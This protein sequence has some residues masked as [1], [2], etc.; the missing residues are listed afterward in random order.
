MAAQARSDDD[1]MLRMMMN[2][3]KILEINPKA[4]LIEGLLDRV[5]EVYGGDEDEDEELKNEHDIQLQETARVL[6]ETTMVKSGFGIED[7][8]G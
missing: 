2:Q 7:K 4:P 8:N 6:F 5:L 3:P 1:A